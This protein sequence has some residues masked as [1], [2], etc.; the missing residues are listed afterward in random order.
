MHNAFPGR[1]EGQ[2]KRINVNRLYHL[3]D[4]IKQ[5]TEYDRVDMFEDDGKDDPVDNAG[6]TG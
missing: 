2:R 3:E 4:K 5:Q 1:T 6:Y